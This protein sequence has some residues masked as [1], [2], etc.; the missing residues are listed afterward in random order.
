MHQAIV[1]NV[2]IEQLVVPAGLLCTFPPEDY[3]K[4]LLE[5]M[6][7]YVI[8]DFGAFFNFKIEPMNSCIGQV[9]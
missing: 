4:G 1:D 2:V 6:K 9:E 3:R 7:D 8:F 5:I